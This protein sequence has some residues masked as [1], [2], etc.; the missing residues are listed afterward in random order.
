LTLVFGEQTAQ[1]CAI[2]CG[3]LKDSIFVPNSQNLGDRKCLGDPRKSIVGHPDAI[4]FLRI[5]LE[6]VFQQPRLITTV[7]SVNSRNRFCES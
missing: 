6:G 2:A 5:S 3:L 4:L 7:T 1:A